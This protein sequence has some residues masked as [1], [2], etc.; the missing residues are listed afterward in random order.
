VGISE[1]P[2][3]LPNYPVIAE[4]LTYGGRRAKVGR[5]LVSACDLHMLGLLE[6]DAESR[7]AAFA[8]AALHLRQAAELFLRRIVLKK[9]GPIG[10]V[11]PRFIGELLKEVKAGPKTL[12]AGADGKSLAKELKWLFDFGDIACHPEIRSKDLKWI[13]YTRRA[14]AGRV[15]EGLERFQTSASMVR[16]RS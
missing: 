2:S 11:Q 5:M 4:L 3:V 15:I 8:G 7:D 10:I 12:R 1:V 6:A 9:A 14:T 13:R 16:W